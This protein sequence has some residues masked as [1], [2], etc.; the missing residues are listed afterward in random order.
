MGFRANRAGGSSM[1]SESA[2]FSPLGACSRGEQQANGIGHRRMDTRGG[3]RIRAG[4]AD[5]LRGNPATKIRDF[6]PTIPASDQSENGI[7]FFVKS[8]EKI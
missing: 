4:K 2:Q 7:D 1:M 8:S 6:R 5:P 3:R